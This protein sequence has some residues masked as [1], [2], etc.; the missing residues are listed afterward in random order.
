[1]ATLETEKLRQSLVKNGFTGLLKQSLENSVWGF[2]QLCVTQRIKCCQNIML[3][4]PLDPLV[5][6][7]DICDL[8]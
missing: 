3:T 8:L 7:L 1:M 4:L 6:Q 2:R 5:A